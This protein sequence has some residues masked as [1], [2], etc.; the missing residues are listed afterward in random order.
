MLTTVKSTVWETPR[1]I[2]EKHPNCKYI[3][4]DFSDVN[5][6]RGHLY[7][8][9]NDRGS[10]LELCK[11]SDDLA[12]QGIACCIMGEYQEGGMIGVLREF[13]G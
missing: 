1:E 10:F 9:S 7:A 3:L 4:T 8:V 2:E 13:A 11:M 5:D 12:L 6:M